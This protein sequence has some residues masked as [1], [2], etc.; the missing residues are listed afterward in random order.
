MQGRGVKVEEVG[1]AVI[2]YAN[3]DV[4]AGQVK[5]GLPSGHGVRKTG[6]FGSQ[7]ASVYTGEWSQGVRAGY[8]VLDDIVRG[9]KYMGLW[10]ADLR[11]G[12]GMVVTMNGVYYEGSFHANKLTVSAFLDEVLEL[13]IV[14]LGSNCVG[15]SS[16]WYGWVME[17]KWRSPGELEMFPS[18]L[19]TR[20]SL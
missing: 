11:Q 18:R 1:Q 3:G 5:D 12:P 2:R 6:H 17:M 7:A 4:Y 8:G 19:R 20:Q 14:T 10:Q 9:E 15:V 16:H 13:V